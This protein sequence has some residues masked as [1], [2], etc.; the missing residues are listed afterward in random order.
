LRLLEVGDGEDLRWLLAHQGAAN[1]TAFVTSEGWRL[2][3]RSRRFWQSVL[4]APETP[5]G[6]LGPALWPLS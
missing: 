5:A 6:E 3:R 2:S 1:L 4:G